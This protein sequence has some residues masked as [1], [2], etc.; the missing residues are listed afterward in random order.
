M[1]SDNPYAPGYEDL[2]ADG[3]CKVKV[4]PVELLKRGFA[5]IEGEYWP[6]FGVTVGGMMI[7]SFVPMG[8]IFGAMM[9]GIYIC[10]LDR[11][12]GR[13]VDMGNMF[14]GFEQFVDSLITTLIIFACSLVL[15]IPIMFGLFGVII[16]TMISAEQT[17]GEPNPAPIIVAFAIFYPLIFLASIACSIPFVFA[18]PLIA[19]RKLKAL[20]AIK[21]SVRGVWTNFRGVLW[22]TLFNV[23]ISIPLALMCYVPLLFFMPIAFAASFQLYRDVFPITANVEVPGYGMSEGP[24][25]NYPPP[26]N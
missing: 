7:A 1:S 10:F 8:I 24:E 4:K 13:R 14:A 2:T 12:R 5:F 16:M 18:F 25:A 21:L 11:E 26:A 23:L 19:E 9:I 20:D 22:Y 3:V 15:M 6:F 17:G